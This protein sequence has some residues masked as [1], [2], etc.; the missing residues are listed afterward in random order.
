MLLAA[1]NPIVISSIKH[2]LLS[3]YPNVSLKVT[4]NGASALLDLNQEVI[5]IAI[6][7]SK[8]PMLNGLEILQK[9]DDQ[10]KKNTKFILLNEAIN[11]EDFQKAKKLGFVAYLHSVDLENELEACINSVFNRTCFI[12]KSMSQLIEKFSEISKKLASLS[13]REILFLNEIKAGKNHKEISDKLVLSSKSINQITSSISKKLEI[14]HEDQ[15][16]IE[17][18]QENDSI[19]N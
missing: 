13:P 11:M 2:I 7:D 10:T 19:F 5:D 15:A 3:K 8:L 9:C 1:N 17:W 16:L 6:L 18:T 4:N 14:S 12:S